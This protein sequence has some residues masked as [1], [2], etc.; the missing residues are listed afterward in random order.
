MPAERSISPPIISMISPQEMIA[1][2]A[3]NCDRFS[4]LALL[5]RKSWLA[6]SK[7]AISTIATSR[8][9]ASRH[10]RKASS[11]PGRATVAAGFSVATWLISRSLPWSCLSP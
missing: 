3:M 8:M 2:G 5:S 4:R 7:Y 10:R 6:L 1:A 9:L 11:R